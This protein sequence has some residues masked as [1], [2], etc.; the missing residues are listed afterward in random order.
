MTLLYHITALA[1]IEL[2]VPFVHCCTF[3]MD[4]L[5]PFIFY[6]NCF[7]V[8]MPQLL[9]LNQELLI[10]QVLLVRPV[11]CCVGLEHI[12]LQ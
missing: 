4:L 7:R 3:N 5:N 1:N 6:Q 8:Q 10:L 9:K 11:V 2:L 12:Q